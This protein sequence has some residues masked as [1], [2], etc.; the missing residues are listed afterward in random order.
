[1]NVLLRIIRT[2]LA[3]EGAV[4]AWKTLQSTRRL[5]QRREHGDQSVKDAVGL[6]PQSRVGDIPNALLALVYFTLMTALS[7]TGAVDRKFFRPL[8]LLS[9][10]VSLAFSG[11]FLFQLWFVLKR[12]CPMC[13]RT[14]SLNLALT[15]AITVKAGESGQRRR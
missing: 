9:A 14:H 1:M 11:Y 5:E 15:L 6:T 7:V 10:W 8:T 4:M 12:N 2:V 13:L 3:V